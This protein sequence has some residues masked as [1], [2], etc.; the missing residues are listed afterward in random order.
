MN[1]DL[2]RQSLDEVGQNQTP[3]T[4]RFYEI[5]F[6]RYPMVRPLFGRR[7]EEAQ[8]KMLQESIVA[9]VEHLDN[10]RWLATHLRSLGRTHRDYGVTAAMYSWVGECLLAA[11]ADL[12]GDRWS[13][14][15]ETAWATTYGR[16]CHIMLEGA[17]EEMVAPA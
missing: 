10:D 9:V 12:S 14:E 4:A 15:L 3:L 6:Q 11:L 7:S 1:Q 8:A 17:I 5:L 13:R 16:I 2:L